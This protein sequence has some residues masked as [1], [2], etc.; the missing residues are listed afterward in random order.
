M[1]C[2]QAEAT[3]I[4]I[5][6]PRL[7]FESTVEKVAA[8]ELYSRFRGV[9]LECATASRFMN[10]SGKCEFL[11]LVAFVENPVVVKSTAQLELLVILINISS[12]WFC[13]CEI[14]RRSFDRGSF[15]GGNHAGVNRRVLL[16][17]Y[18]NLYLI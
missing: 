8:V 4:E 16:R 2:F 7:S 3:A 14:E 11:L 12:N 5:G 10:P 13:R 15:A 9:D 1:L 6:F 17:I 18:L